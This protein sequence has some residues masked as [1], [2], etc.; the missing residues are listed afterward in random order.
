VYRDA[1]NRYSRV[2]MFHVVLKLPQSMTDFP[3]GAITRFTRAFSERV[4][5]DQLSRGSQVARVHKTDT[6]YVWCREV[7]KGERDHYHVMF[8][9]NGNA[10]R[11]LGDFDGGI[12]SHI[13]SMLKEA[14]ASA[15][16]LA[17]HQISGLVHFSGKKLISRADIAGGPVID[18]YGTFNTKYEAGFYWLSYLCKC[19]S[20]FYAPGRRNFGCSQVAGGSVFFWLSH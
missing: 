2:L 6:H 12:P 17:V 14:W 3:N 13:T 1:F 19:E 9:V 4:S 18:K 11:Q 20:K 16:Q 8:M 5:R 15:L 7:G 10:Y